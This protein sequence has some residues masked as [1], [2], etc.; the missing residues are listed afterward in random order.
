MKNFSHSFSRRSFLARASSLG[1]LY[2]AAELARPLP[3]LAWPPLDDARIAPQPI[4]DKGYASIRKI[5]NGLYALISDRSKG[6]QTRS[7]G[8]FMIGRDAALMVEG[9]QT[10]IGCDLSIGNAAYHYPS[11]CARGAQHPLAFRPHAGQ[12]RVWRRG[13]TIWAHADRP[14]AWP[15]ITPSGKPKIS[16]HFSRRGKSGCAMPGPTP[17]ASTPKAT[18]R[19]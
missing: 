6:M 16:R 3:A 5:G 2:A 19:A 14:R 9:F 18:S 4:A 13:N 17:S 10:T 12:F 11:A 7:N 1:A 15:R 8:G